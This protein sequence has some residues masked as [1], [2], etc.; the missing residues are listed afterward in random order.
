MV[1]LQNADIEKYRYS[2]YGTGFDRR[3]SFS[4]PGGRFGQNVII[5]GADM[6]SSIHIDNKKKD[7]LVL[8]RGPTQ[9]L[10]STLT[11]EKMY[12][13]KFT[14]TKKKFCLSLC[15]NGA[16]S[17]LFVNVTEIYKF[18]AKDSE[19]VVSPLCLGNI[20]KDWSTDNMQKTGLTGY[21]YDFSVD[22]NT[23]TVDDI[24]DIHNYL[25]KKNN[26]I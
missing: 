7:I 21:V 11:A 17:Y 14:V 20:S 13:I 2:G 8:G 23:V 3:S 4:F 9:G 25:M 6:S 19:I 22:N 26:M 1:Q 16:N 12:S 5:F 15:Y 24:K 10:E 18:K